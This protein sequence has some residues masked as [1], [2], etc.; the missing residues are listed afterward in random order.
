MVIS[1]FEPFVNQDSETL[2]LGSFPSVKSREENFF[3]GNKLNRFWKTLSD[4]FGDPTP[5]TV[6]EKKEFLT[7]HK[8]ALWDIVSKCEIEGSLDANIKNPQ[9]CDLTQ[10]FKVATIKKIIVNGMVAKKLFK[11]S[12]PLLN[13]IAFYLPSTSP[14]NTHF[15]YKAWEKA[16]KADFITANDF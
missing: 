16:I 13:K 9:I 8:I 1:A 15:D 2:I 11:K 12:Y 10:I 4:I 7:K 14:A 6:E 3:Y 5:V